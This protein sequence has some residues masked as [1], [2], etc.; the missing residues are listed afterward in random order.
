MPDY[1][2]KKKPTAI[3]LRILIALSTAHF[4][5]DLLQSIITASYPILRDELSL[6]F[7]QIGLISLVYQIASSVF[8]PISGYKDA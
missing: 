4:I 5:N 6:S 7:S 1:M 2:E 3:A 8:Q